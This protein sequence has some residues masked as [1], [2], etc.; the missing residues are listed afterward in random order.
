MS[1]LPPDSS[2][3]DGGPPASGGADP[4]SIVAYLLSGMLIWGGAGWLLD[5]WLETSFL[6]LV[7]LLLGTAL[8]IYLIYIRL[9]S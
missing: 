4:W 8:A 1:H 5:R 2:G 7:G 9:G 3:A 6:V